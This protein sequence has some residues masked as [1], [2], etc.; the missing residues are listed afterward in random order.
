[1]QK[2]FPL[3]FFFTILIIIGVF[4]G[5]I[6]P[7]LEQIQELQKNIRNKEI[8]YE[9]I[10]TSIQNLEEI[11]QKLKKFPEQIFKI[12]QALPQNPNLEQVL[13]VIRNLAVQNG[14]LLKGIDFGSPRKFKQERDILILPI[15]LKVLGTYQSFKSFLSAIERS[16][17]IFN[18]ELI[19]FSAP[20]DEII[21]EIIYSFDLK[22]K[23][24]FY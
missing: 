21:D 20:R 3:L 24:H 19:A 6:L 1:M 9:M 7:R 22:M 5:L 16:A 8:E 11:S 23:I 10:K 4:F 12:E 2:L 17:R 13:V 14:V 18:V 15:D